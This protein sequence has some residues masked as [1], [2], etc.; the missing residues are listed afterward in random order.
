MLVT[1]RSTIIYMIKFLDHK[2]KLNM[3]IL[4]AL[5]LLLPLNSFGAVSKIVR[6]VDSDTFIVSAP[7]LP[8]PLKQ[9]M[10]MRLIGVDAPGIKRWANCDKEAERGQT[11]KLFV[12]EL[13]KNSKKQYVEIKGFDKYN[14]LLGNVYLD[15]KNLAEILV[16]K[17]YGKKYDGGK[18]ES[19]CH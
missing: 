8:K 6:I 18:K 13:I 10:P 11:A 7:F 15:N 4:L 16:S 17:G 1:P 12:E 19:W 9:Q 3:K 5:L 14:R 2:R